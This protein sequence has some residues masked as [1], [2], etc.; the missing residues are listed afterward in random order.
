ML[1]VESFK[2]QIRQVYSELDKISNTILRRFLLEKLDEN[3]LAKIFESKTTADFNSLKDYEKNQIL[4]ILA[5]RDENKIAKE[6]VQYLD[7]PY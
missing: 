2:E 3:A 4:T 5:G 6:I 7:N 1:T